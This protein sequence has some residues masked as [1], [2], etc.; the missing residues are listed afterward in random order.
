M[1][2]TFPLGIFPA[3][4]FRAVLLGSDETG[5]AALGGAGQVIDWSAGGLW[6]AELSGMQLWEPDHFRAFRALLLACRGGGEI[7]VPI[8][9]DPQRPFGD[10]SE[11]TEPV[12]FSDEA[13]FSDGAGFVGQ[14]LIF[15]AVAPALEGDVSMTLQRISGAAL[16][17]GEYW[18]FDHAAAGPRAYCGESLGEEDEDG[19]FEVSFGTP[20]REDVAVGELADF[21]RPRVRMRLLTPWSDA[22][23][24]VT[25]PFEAEAALRFIESFNHL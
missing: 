20:L 14:D 1:A 5:G 16:R 18:S 17:G 22:W 4:S 13:L 3:G 25:A 6:A 7:D 11:T 24:L 2:I 23:P 12:P 21:Q 15:E 19:I 9:D 10:L 8:I